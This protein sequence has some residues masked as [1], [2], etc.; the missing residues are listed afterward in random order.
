MYALALEA[1]AG[2]RVVT[3]LVPGAIGHRECFQLLKE[4]LGRGFCVCCL[5][6]IQD[7][8]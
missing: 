2:E 4:H 8:P 5:E 1:N 3:I 6:Q 7:H